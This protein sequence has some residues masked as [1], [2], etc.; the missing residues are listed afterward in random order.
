[1]NHLFGVNGRWPCAHNLTLLSADGTDAAQGEEGGR[2][3]VPGY[4]SEVL[5]VHIQRRW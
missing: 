2:G 5:A 3:G 1:M 4:L